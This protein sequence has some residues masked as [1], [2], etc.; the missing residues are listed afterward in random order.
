[1]QREA[2]G[3]PISNLSNLQDFNMVK[4]ESRPQT[5]NLQS[6]FYGHGD[7]GSLVVKTIVVG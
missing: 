5:N 7:D 4:R 1:M 2:S 6:G 3:R